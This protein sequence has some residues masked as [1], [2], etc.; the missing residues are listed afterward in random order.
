MDLG[1]NE[2]KKIDGF[3]KKMK[4]GKPARYSDKDKIIQSIGGTQGDGGLLTKVEGGKVYWNFKGK[5]IPEE[6]M[7]R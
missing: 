4:E 7:I 5:W 3:I 6:D 1:G 2:M